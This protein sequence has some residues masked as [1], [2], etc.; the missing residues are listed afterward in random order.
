MKDE[1]KKSS[2]VLV[3]DMFIRKFMHGTWN[4]VFVSEV[5]IKRRLNMVVI[6]GLI[7]MNIFPTKIYFLTGY[8]EELL[9]HLLKKPVKIEIQSVKHHADMHV[10]Y[11]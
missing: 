1:E 8:T 4:N 2:E 3:E 5:I 9:T 11:I 10:K 7:K 6:A